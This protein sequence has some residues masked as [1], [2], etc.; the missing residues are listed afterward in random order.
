M[1]QKRSRKTPTHSKASLPAKPLNSLVKW[2]FRTRWGRR[3]L[4]AVNVLIL[5]GG[6]GWYLAQPAE[7]RAEIRLLVG[8]YMDKEKQVNFPELAWDLWS[9]YYGD[10]FVSSDF[11]GGDELVYGGAPD[12][13]KLP[14]K[15]RLL[16]NTGYAA[17]YSDAMK[18]PVWI[19]YRLFD[20]PE[21]TPPG[22]RPENFNVDKRTF[23]QVRSSDY[24][25]SGYDRGHLAPNYGIALCY[26]REAQEETFLMSNIIPQ[27]HGLNAGPWKEMEMKAA[28][29]Y[30]ARFQ[31]IWIIAGPVFGP[32]PAAT[33][34]GIPIPEACYKIM[35]DET[36]GKLRVQAFLMPQDIPEGAEP[37]H[38]LTSVDEIEKRV[39]IDFLTALDDK[40]ENELEARIPSSI[41]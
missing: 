27:K 28:V 16:T 22:E 5:L 12:T 29:N 20:L 34:G 39:S 37:K 9:Y 40:A 14:T 21:L 26:G 24:T 19:A 38:F 41:W 31:E 1:A 17:G 4:V 13:S 36:G 18:N 32:S 35:I 3:T 23:A 7:R 8:N 30:P 15:V 33:K 6:G 11:E 2:I 10:Q 25:G